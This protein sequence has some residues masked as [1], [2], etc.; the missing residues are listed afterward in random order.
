M[1]AVR[2]GVPV[3]GANLPREQM[4]AAMDK[5]ELD[6]LLK[7][8]ALKAQQQ[9]IRIGHCE[10]LPENQITPMT[11]IQIARDISMAQTVAGASVRGKTVLLLAGASH[12]DRVLGVPQHLRPELKAIAIG[13][14]ADPAQEASEMPARFDAL[15][16]ALPAPEVDHCAD[17][18]LRKTS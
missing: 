3:L 14:V 17:F 16:P 11:R 6:L 4:R 9:R 12:V 8:P 5:R 10:Q 2:A 15:W 7:G 18:K 1:L 13:M